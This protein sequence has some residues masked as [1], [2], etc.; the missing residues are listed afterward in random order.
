MEPFWEVVSELLNRCDTF[1]Q[2]ENDG[3]EQEM[4]NSVDSLL[5]NDSPAEDAVL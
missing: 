1:S 2:K 5:Q 4:K 3:V